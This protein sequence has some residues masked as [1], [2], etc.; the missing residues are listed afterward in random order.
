[1]QEIGLGATAAVDAGNE[2]SGRAQALR[3]IADAATM[4]VVTGERDRHLRWLETRLGVS[5]F[6]RGTE[7]RIDGPTAAVRR[8]EQVLDALLDRIARGLPLDGESF[9][10]AVEESAVR[11]APVA[12]VAERRRGSGRART[13]NQRRYLDAIARHDVVF[14]CGPAGTGKTFLAVAMAVEALERA[15]IKRI[16][17]TRPAVEAGERLGFLPGDLVAKVNPYLRPLLDALGDLL[18]PEG[19]ERLIERGRIEIA[20]LAFM[21]GRTLSNA[22]VILDEAQN[23]T[24]EQMAM[25]LTRIGHDSKVVVTGDPSQTDLPRT[26]RSG[27]DHALAI[28]EGI[29]GIDIVRFGPEDVVRHP[30]VARI[31]AAYEA[32]AQR[33]RA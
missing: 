3:R 11:N 7:L 23:C 32:A 8:T 13:E 18:D 24:V 33:E 14:G 31:A 15:E 17:L 12:R 22:F 19:V 5:I 9:R 1:V 25:L 10:L 16:I 30:L 28:L 4:L 2:A 20:P 6:A 29:E 27:L 21:R 26:Q